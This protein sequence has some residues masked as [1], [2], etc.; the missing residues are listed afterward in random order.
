MRSV[1]DSISVIPL[2]RKAHAGLVKWSVR[3]GALRLWNALARRR[4]LILTFHQIRP[5]GRLLDPFDTCPSASVDFFREILTY[6]REQFAFLPLQ[7]LCTARV[8]SKPLAAVTFDDGWRDNYDLAF[9][10]L[11]ELGIPA[12][13]FVTTGKIG[14]TELFWQQALGRAFHRAAAHPAG[15][16]G[17]RLRRALSGDEGAPPT[18]ELY[19]QTVS[20]W[21][22]LPP[23]QRKERLRR[24]DCLP[25]A[26][27]E[28]SRCFLNVEEIRE[29]AAAGLAFGSHTVTH[30]L[31]PQLTASEMDREL[32]ESKDCLE[33]LLRRPIEMIA[34]PD[35][36]FSEAVLDRV[37]AAGYRIGCTTQRRRIGNGKDGLCLS[38][39]DCSWYAAGVPDSFLPDVF[40]WQT[41]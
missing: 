25:S 1:R 40:E 18:P 34:Y 24:A 20:R 12:T 26:P 38:R 37:R 31:L 35:G 10:V 21:K 11:R 30:P 6:G 3:S 33:D 13:I 28:D 16:S 19:R 17:R 29:M 39:I 14:S 22:R 15:E 32:R 8:G 2:A 7:D 5:P 4:R 23:D 27:A 41:R 9:P 36:A